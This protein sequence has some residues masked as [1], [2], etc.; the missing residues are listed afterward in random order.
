MYR[1][2]NQKIPIGWALDKHG[3]PTTDPAVAVKARRLSPLGGTAS[4]KGTG[5][6]IMVEILSGLLA[7]IFFQ[8]LHDD[9]GVITILF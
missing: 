9:I 3:K 8:A 1:R 5:L 2:R 6:A 7:S 4:H